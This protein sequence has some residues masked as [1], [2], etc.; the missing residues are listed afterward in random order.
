MNSSPPAAN[1]VQISIILPV[2]NVAE[3]LP[4][5]LQSIIDQSYAVFI[6]SKFGVS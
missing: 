5:C 2:Y 1:P 3:Y 6:W 4:E